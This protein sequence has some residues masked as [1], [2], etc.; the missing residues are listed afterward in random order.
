MIRFQ[1]PV[2]GTTM[3]TFDRLAGGKRSCAKCGTAVQVPLTGSIPGKGPALPQPP[4][5]TP[6]TVAREPPL[7]NAWC[8]IR[9]R[10]G[11]GLNVP[12]GTKSPG[13]RGKGT[14]Q[15]ANGA[16]TISGIKRPS[17]VIATSLAVGTSL[18]VKL[19]LLF[20]SWS[21]DATFTAIIPG[22]PLLCALYYFGLRRDVDLVILPRTDQTT[23][24]I[25]DPRRHRFCLHVEENTWVTLWSSK[26]D[27]AQLTKGLQKEYGPR[28]RL[29][30]L[31][32][33]IW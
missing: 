32:T 15:I 14:M 11:G 17:L 21:S 1:C 22:V 13:I 25:H 19:I 16:I 28:M 27:Y 7:D 2:C 10:L 30:E 3:E 26:G 23:E 18:L 31:P 6:V 9:I 24:A 5:P 33:R 8:E 12:R 4:L 29:G 20:R